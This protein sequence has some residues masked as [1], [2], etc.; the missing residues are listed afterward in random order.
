[1]KINQPVAIIISVVI[2]SLIVFGFFQGWFESVKSESENNST[3]Q[4]EP[5]LASESK[6]Q[7]R[8]SAQTSDSSPLPENQPGQLTVELTEQ[9]P[10]VQPPVVEIPELTQ[11]TVRQ[12]YYNRL[13]QQQPLT[14]WQQWTALLE[15]TD[16]NQ[17]LAW[18]LI[19][20]ALPYRLQNGQNQ[21]I[22]YQ[23]MA[24][25]LN[26]SESSLKAREQTIQILGWTATVP[27]LQ[28]LLDE[29]V[30]HSPDSEIRLKLLDAIEQLADIRWDNRFHPELSPLLEK[31][32]QQV[33]YTDDM[34]LL[35][36]I[37]VAMAKIGA[38]DGVEL[39]FNSMTDREADIQEQPPQVIAALKAIP[40]VR[41][42]VSV[43]L[44][45]KQLTGYQPDNLI[46]RVSGEALATMGHLQA[47]KHLFQ[48]AT[49]APDA[50]APLTNDWFSL[51]RDTQSWNW[52]VTQ[53]DENNGFLSQPVK[54]AVINGIENSR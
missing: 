31:T 5:A 35:L 10:A 16:N 52:I 28:I 13:L 3:V 39:L 38:P 32:W 48:W 2:I 7:K 8:L 26:H 29:T 53:L 11:I 37:G 44:I 41:N 25:L 19:G 22:V 21:E 17:Q 49:E 9:P 42:P 43:P 46:F 50:A 30:P 27:A 6:P 15:A 1:M 47:T 54:Q 18:M 20:Y 14:L 24:E 23:Q 33:Q 45:A 51:I 12:D 36:T 40:E 4:T 34:P